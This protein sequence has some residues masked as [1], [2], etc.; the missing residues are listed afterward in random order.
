MNL[1][2]LYGA[3]GSQLGKRSSTIYSAAKTAGKA[4]QKQL[5]NDP[6]SGFRSLSG[7]V[8]KQGALNAA[9]NDARDA[10]LLQAG[11][12]FTRKVGLT[13]GGVGALGLR[14]AA[15]RPGPM[16]NQTSYRGPSQTGVGSGRYA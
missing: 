16:E 8:A 10:H 15:M 2:R 13:A 4:A 11:K 5:K 6:A 14:N 12:S 9:F 7:R 1:N 3:V